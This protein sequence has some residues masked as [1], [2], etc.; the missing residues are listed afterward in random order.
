MDL[1]DYLIMLVETYNPNKYAKTIER[2]AK[3]FV[4]FLLITT[5]I[6]LLLFTL[7][8][9]P[10]AYHYASSIPERAAQ[11]DTFVINAEVNASQPIEIISEPSIILDIDANGTRNGFITLSREGIIYPKYLFFGTEQLPWDQLRDVKQNTVERDRLLWGTII[12]LLPSILFWFFFFSL[13]ATAALFCLLAL[14]GY[15]LPRIFKYRMSA[16]EAAK[17]AIIAMPSVLLFGL[18]LYPLGVGTLLWVSIGLSLVLFGIGVAVIS[19]LDMPEEH[20]KH[21]GK[22]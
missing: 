2:P 12:F 5:G 18:G 21:H 3:Q 19:E 9:I 16:T 1:G 11:M 22:V 20:R 6:A 10:V 15:A 14:L 13:L 4:Q 8:I 17:V 7:L